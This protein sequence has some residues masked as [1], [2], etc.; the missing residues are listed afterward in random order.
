KKISSGVLGSHPMTKSNAVVIGGGV[1]GVC[2]AYYLA[3][4]GWNVTLLEQNDICAGC[5]Y[6]NAGMVVPSHSIPLAAPGVWLKGL[7]WMLD[8]E[9]PLYIKPQLKWD[10]LAWLWRFRGSCNAAHVHRAMPLLRDLSNA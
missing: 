8:P 7:K 6:G 9:S 1:V 4:E 10:L 2:S 5:S 3:R